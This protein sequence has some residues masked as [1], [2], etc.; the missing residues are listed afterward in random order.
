[1][2]PICDRSQE[3]LG[4]TDSMIIQTRRR[5]LKAAKALRSTGEAPP[6]VD[7]PAVYAQ[8]SGGVILPRG[9]HWFE[10]TRELRRAFIDHPPD[11]VR[12]TIGSQV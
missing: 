6:G 3:H 1:M 8:R 4:A 5:L 10:A 12:A 2:G 7:A 9:A 11:V